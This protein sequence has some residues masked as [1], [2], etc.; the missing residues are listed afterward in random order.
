MS[1][2]PE[3]Q[4]GP[5]S[6]NP[7]T[8][9]YILKLFV[10]GTNL[11]ASHAINNISKFCEKFLKGRYTLEIIDLNKEPHWASKENIF[12]VPLLIKKN[13][14]PEERLIGDLSDT[15]KIQS[16]FNITEH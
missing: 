13:P 2:Q 16:I 1:N 11:D 5:E 4:L 7:D 3:E 6:D 12:A 14:F 8:H 9:K 15:Q 10:I